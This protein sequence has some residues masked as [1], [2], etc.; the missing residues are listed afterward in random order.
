MIRNAADELPSLEYHSEDG[1]AEAKTLLD[2][3]P[4]LIGRDE[5]SDLQVRSGR[6]SRRHAVITREGDNFCVEDLDSTNGTFLNGQRI[7]E[8]T[9][10]SGDMLTVGD[11]EFTFNAG[12]AATPGPMATQVMGD[13]A[14]GEQQGSVWSTVFQIRR[15]QEML[16]E[17]CVPIVFEPIF[18]LEDG[19]VFGYEAHSAI[20]GPA[21]DSMA[22]LEQQLMGVECR[23]T[24]RLR[25]LRRLVAVEQAER[26][27]GAEALLLR[28]HSSEIGT[29][30]LIDSLLNLRRRSGANRPLV[31]ALPTDVV[32]D[33][34]Y[35]RRFH[36][37]LRRDGI[38]IAYD[39]FMGGPIA[40]IEQKPI[41]PDY[42]RL[43]RSLIRGIQRTPDRQHQVEAAVRQARSAGCRVIAPAIRS[44]EE[45]ACCRQLGC[46]L[47][48]G[49]VYER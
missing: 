5:S 14:R 30:E 6:V 40:G 26:L 49:K 20:N 2:P 24:A 39:N 23:L 18:R 44:E 17:R 4:M 35:F 37:R 45:L 15:M 10:Q 1:A 12:R 16:I 43:A 11:V 48:Q 8:A 19:G 22:E 13:P 9:L 34:E 3:L 38:G 27:G 28:V 7:T 42:L 33:A 21:G 31:V 32:S 41:R 29:H 36:Q 46:D 25:Q 47:A